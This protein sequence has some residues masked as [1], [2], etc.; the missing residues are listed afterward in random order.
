MNKA[1]TVQEQTAAES[2][3]IGFDYQYYY[4]LLKMLQLK[5]G[6]SIGY[7]VKDDVHL[8]KVDEDLHENIH[9]NNNNKKQIFYQL[10]HSVSKK[11]DKTI[12][13]LTEKDKDLW[14]T[15]STWVKIIND[16]ADGRVDLQTQIEF[17]NETKFHLITNKS[18]SDTNNFL[19]NIK[20][21]NNNDFSL[22]D[23]LSYL[24]N[25]INKEENSIVDEYIK[26]LIKQKQKWLIAFFNN[27]VIEHNK[28]DLIERIKLKIKE[29][30]VPDTRVD[31]VFASID[32][33]LRRLM[34][35]TV[36]EENKILITFERY[37]EIFTNYFEI[38]RLKKLPIRLQ[39]NKQSIPSNILDFVFIKQLLES[40][41]MDEN[42]EGFKDLLVNIFTNKY[43]MNNN[44][45]QWLQDSDIT[46]EKV[47]SFDKDSIDKWKLNFDR[48]HSKLTRKL[49]KSELSS[50]AIEELLDL[51]SD[52]YHE[53][54]KLELK[55]DE[56][57]LSTSMSNGQFYLLSD[58]PKIGWHFSWKER[59]TQ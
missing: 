33:N 7:E 25:L 46:I 16:K 47:Q 45:T 28:D 48:I 43:E 32:S 38:G 53:T 22:K 40:Q 26:L 11:A 15:I 50:I 34:Y 56:T 37:H 21:I 42:D 10:K 30:N 12:I 39:N 59:Y 4:F 18:M 54:L 31:D 52:C 55:I 2:K 3:S 9:L 23:M 6:E 51:A 14:K 27:L 5:S 49:R 57:E 8:D 35:N 41:I 44:L 58:Q 24:S 19:V 17:I 29:K 36:K 1:R 13:N 20:K